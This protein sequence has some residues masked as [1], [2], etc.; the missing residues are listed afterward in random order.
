MKTLPSPLSVWMAVFLCLEQLVDLLPV[1]TR[2]VQ[3]VGKRPVRFDGEFDVRLV[4]D[5]GNACAVCQH[6]QAGSAERGPEISIRRQVDGYARDRSDIKQPF[7]VACSTVD[8]A[9]SNIW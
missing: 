8:L 5:I 2:R 9:S 1:I 7:M 3:P 4:A 6:R